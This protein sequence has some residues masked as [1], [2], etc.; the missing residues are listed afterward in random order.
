MSENDL[1]A[2]R[3]VGGFRDGTLF[4]QHN[5]IEGRKKIDIDSYFGE[6]VLN[7]GKGNW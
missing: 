3:C 6:E 4:L 2:V 5:S 1:K 7:F